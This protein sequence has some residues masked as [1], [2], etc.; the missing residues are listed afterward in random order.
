MP[1]LQ[2]SHQFKRSEGIIAA[3]AIG[4]ENSR[5]LLLRRLRNLPGKTIIPP[6]S[7]RVQ[8]E[9]IL[10][11]RQLISQVSKQLFCEAAV[12]DPRCKADPVISLKIS[13]SI[14]HN[15]IRNIDQDNLRIRLA[16]GIQKLFRIAMMLRIIT[17]RRCFHSLVLPGFISSHSPMLD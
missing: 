12:I 11:L 7:R 15:T 14:L 4:P 2:A 16:N 1:L 13:R 5:L 8:E 10:S 6:G 17:N 9:N 3:A